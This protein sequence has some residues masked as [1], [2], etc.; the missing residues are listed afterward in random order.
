M[1]SMKEVR[2]KIK[3]PKDILKW[4]T[5]NCGGKVDNQ[6]LCKKCNKQYLF[7]LK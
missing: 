3:N 7:T 4:D 2:I 5:C 1:N 6:Y